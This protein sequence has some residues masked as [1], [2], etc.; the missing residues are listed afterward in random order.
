MVEKKKKKFQKNFEN[1]FNSLSNK[2]DKNFLIKFLSNKPNN[3]RNYFN[4]LSSEKGI[5]GECDPELFLL[6]RKLI[7]E[8]SK[9]KI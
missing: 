3:L 7:Y 9:K 5:N 2:T 4:L 6:N 1:L 8:I